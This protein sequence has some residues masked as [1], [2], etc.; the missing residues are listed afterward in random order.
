[1]DLQKIKKKDILSNVRVANEM[2]SLTDLWKLAGSDPQR[3]PA[4]WQESEPVQRFIQTACKF[5]NVGISDIIKSK[6][7]KGGGTWG[8]KQ[9]ALEYSQYLD[10]RYAVLVNEVF[11]ERIEEEKNPELILERWKNKYR[12]SG[13][14]EKWI[15]QRYHSTGTRKEFTATL[16]SHGVSGSGYKDCT[17]AIYIGFYGKNA[18]ALR[19]EK[20]IEGNIRDSLSTVAL[21]AISLIEGLSKEDIENRRLWGN[22][23]CSQ[24]AHTAATEVRKMIKQ[25]RNR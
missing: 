18:T 7:G 14:D 12:N 2:Y 24:S 15:D 11:F 19:S 10:P 9:V 22:E 6:R 16:K 17:N 8:H 5:L 13:K 3:T 1:M 20:S 25:Y 4:K 21:S 23:Q